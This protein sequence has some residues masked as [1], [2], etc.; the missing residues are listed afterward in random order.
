MKRF[1][2]F[3]LIA[4]FALPAFAEMRV[5]EDKNG[6]QYTA[7]YVRE[8]F[9]KVT[10]RLEDGSEVRL[11]VEELSEHDQ[12]YLRVMVPPQI[13]IDCRV[14]RDYQEPPWDLWHGDNAVLT[15]VQ[16]EVT[17]RKVSKRRFTRRLFAEI[18][19]IAEEVDG[20]HFVLL[21]RT[22]SSFV[23]SDLNNNQHQFVSEPYTTRVYT[24]Y[25]G[26]QRRGEKYHGYLV[27]IKDADENIVK[28]K[29]DMDD[30]IT[31]PDVIANLDELAVRGAPSVRSRHFDKT[32]QKTAVPRPEFYKPGNR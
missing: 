7:E 31:D 18:Y 20:D 1:L 3:S 5:W 27:V 22:E 24:E 13:E 19:V 29:T 26:I 14:N 30:W 25:N 2:F 4:L 21:N 17:I 8:L 28:I 32:G 11:D 23:F 15:K 9:D 6:R 16:A 10:L 12:K